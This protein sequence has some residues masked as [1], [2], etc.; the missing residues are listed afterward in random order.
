MFNS[1]LRGWF[2]TLLVALAAAV[3]RGQTPAAPAV[4]AMLTRGQLSHAQKQLE[5]QLRSTPS[6]DNGRFALGIVQTL[7]GGERLVQALYRYGMAPNELGGMFVFRLPVPHNPHPL[8]PAMR[9]RRSLRRSA[10][11]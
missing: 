3:V 10:R 5:G 8:G 2:V 6:D 1:L 11:G 9:R 7:H 4:E